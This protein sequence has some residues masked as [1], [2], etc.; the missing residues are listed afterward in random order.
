MRL[1]GRQ[2]ARGLRHSPPPGQSGRSTAEERQLGGEGVLQHAT[3]KIIIHINLNCYNN[4]T[5]QDTHTSNSTVSGFYLEN[6]ML[7]IVIEGG[8]KVCPIQMYRNGRHTHYCVVDQ[9]FS[10]RISFESPF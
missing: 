8:R 7:G 9:N 6:I 2:S 5:S 4:T 3:L 10:K 1:D